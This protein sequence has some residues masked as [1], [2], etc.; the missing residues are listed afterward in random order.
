[1][2]SKTDSVKVHKSTTDPKAIATRLREIRIDA[3]LTQKELGK[4]VGL[5]PGSVGALENG[6]YT[7][8][9]DVLRALHK[10]LNV[11]YDYIIDGVKTSHNHQEVEDLQQEVERLRRMVDKLLK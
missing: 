5:T 6:L 4:I 1:M 2:K 11:S 3:R 7:P 10:T 8:N 9:F